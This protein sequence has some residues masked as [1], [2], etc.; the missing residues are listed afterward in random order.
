MSGIPADFAGAN[1]I[2]TTSKKESERAGLQIINLFRTDTCRLEEVVS[3]VVVV[4]HIM[5]S[6]FLKYYIEIFSCRINVL[7]QSSSQISGRIYSENGQISAEHCLMNDCYL[8][9]EPRI[10][11]GRT[12]TSTK[13]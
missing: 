4:W 2:I 8:Q 11:I 9:L 10:K 5:T 13:L 7:I 3:L 6:N 1:D 12:L